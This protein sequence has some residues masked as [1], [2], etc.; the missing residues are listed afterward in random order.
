MVETNLMFG[1]CNYYISLQLKDWLDLSLNHSVPSS[2]LI[3]SRYFNTLSVKM[4]P[5]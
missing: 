2:L 1:G 5:F 3:L 4:L